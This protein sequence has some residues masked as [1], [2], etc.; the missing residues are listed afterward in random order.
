[1]ADGKS[2]AETKS[3]HKWLRTILYILA[4]LLA[5]ICILTIIVIILLYR[6]NKT[7][8]TAPANAFYSAPVS[9]NRTP[10]SV[11]RT[12]TI[13]NGLPANS[14]AV[15]ILYTTTAFDTGN[16]I[17]CSASLF[18]PTTSAPKGGRPVIAW[19]HPTT[20]VS[21]ISAPSL[22]SD[23]GAS[24]VPGLEAFLQQGYAVI[25]TDYPG[26]G[27]QGLHPYLV[28]SSEAR[29][30]LDSVRATLHIKQADASNHFIVWGHSQ[31]GQAALWTGQMAKSYAPELDLVGVAAAAP[32]SELIQL[33][34]ADIDT[35]ASSILGPMVFYTWSK[36]YPNV[37]MQSVV[38]PIAMPMAMKVAAADINN[39]EDLESIVLD[40]VVM[41]KIMIKVNPTT[42]EPWK[43]L[44]QKN[45]AGD[46][47]IGA[48]ILITQGTKDT[49][50]HPEVTE[51]YVN[52]LCSNGEIVYFQLIKG[53]S[54]GVAGNVSAP[55]VALWAQDRFNGIKAPSNCNAQ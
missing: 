31:G 35:L 49:V 40:A 26:L 19:A 17:V 1:M 28:G 5:V 2:Q 51:G 3:R 9:F 25:A 44:M 15:K 16:P 54:H 38:R 52:K 32:A 47:P 55:A 37:S 14:K 33:Y 50:V 22:A 10:G 11:I 36:V 21:S 48:P 29:A 23:G 6:G 43:T 34:D 4:G 7:V 18:F 41:T 42:I 12:E 45:S 39:Q 53:A 27:T 24:M 20:G 30:V 8:Q 46:S 13:S